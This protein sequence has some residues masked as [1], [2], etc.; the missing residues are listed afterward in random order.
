MGVGAGGL[1]EDAD[2]E[3]VVAE[4]LIMEEVDAGAGAE[5]YA[6]TETKSLARSTDLFD[7]HVGYLET[8][9]ERLVGQ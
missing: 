5:A 6:D 9:Y 8:H 7:H 2:V 3:E 1:L 4:E